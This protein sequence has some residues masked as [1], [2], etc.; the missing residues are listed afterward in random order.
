MK[1]FRFLIIA[2]TMLSSFCLNAEEQQGEIDY[3]SLA[4]RLVKDGDYQRAE[5]VLANVPEDEQDT[6]P[7][8]LVKGL[9]N[10]Y[11][12]RF[13]VAVEVFSEVVKNPVEDRYVWIYLGQAYFGKK[14]YQRTLETFS[15]AADLSQS[16]PSVIIIKARAQWELNQKEV[17]WQTLHQYPNYNTDIR[18]IR[19]RVE[20]L[21][22]SGLV[23]QAFRITE[24]TIY[25]NKNT[26]AE[27]IALPTLFAREAAIRESIRLFEILR[28]S[29]P[30]NINL[31]VTLA[32]AYAKAG[33]YHTAG[34]L[35]Q[36]VALRDHSFSYQAVELYRK[37][38][39]Y[40]EALR[41]NRR[42][43]DQSKKFQQRLSILIADGAFEE[44]TS[45]A[46][47]LERLGLL[48]NEEIRYA[49]AF[50]FFKTNQF[51]EVERHLSE[52]QHPDL[53][54]KAIALRKEIDQCRDTKQCV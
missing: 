47:D 21:I 19:L 9:L 36:S 53:F 2:L 51:E 54:K 50:A 8:L 27:L 45:T 35:F 39:R 42:V 7:Y 28:L 31:A 15:Q 26:I 4:G 37:A 10:L 17:A 23:Q 1:T 49:L 44:A 25:Q 5:S 24:E 40:K 6:T 48:Q 16:I 12:E 52:I 32:Y 13:D 41:I 18:F 33:K 14:D 20:W 34:D 29:Y 30:E 22:S 11:Q 3:I 43:K 38:G 46:S